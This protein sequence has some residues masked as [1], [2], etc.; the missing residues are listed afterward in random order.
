M[1]PK[2]FNGKRCAANTHLH[3]D[4]KAVVQFSQPPRTSNG[5]WGALVEARLSPLLLAP[6]RFRPLTWSVGTHSGWEESISDHPGDGAQGVS[7]LKVVTRNK[8]W[9]RPCLCF[10]DSGVWYG[11]PSL[12]MRHRSTR[13]TDACILPQKPTSSSTILFLASKTP[14]AAFAFAVSTTNPDCSR[15]AWGWWVG[16]VG[17]VSG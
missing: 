4:V 14:A 2:Y 11:L 5:R 17:W 6:G 9:L 16:G 15:M 1:T 10:K 13:H 7:A 3:P 8:K 12:Q